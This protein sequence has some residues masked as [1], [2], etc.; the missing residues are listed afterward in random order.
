VLR[1]GDSAVITARDESRVTDLVEGYKDRAISTRL[2]VTNA[3]DVSEAVQRGVSTF[4]RIDILVNNAGYGYLGAIEESV[5]TDI[6]DMFDTNFFGLARM[7]HA[8]LPGMRQR[9]AG[10]IINISSIAGF[11]GFPS[12]GYYSASK[13]AVE[14]F[15]E[16]L[17]QEVSPLGIKVTIV[18]PGGF[19]T[20]W[21]GRSIKQSALRIA[22]YSTTAG[23]VHLHILASYGHAIGDPEKAAQQIIGAAELEEPPRRLVLGSDALKSARERVLHLSQEIDSCAATAGNTDFDKP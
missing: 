23:A 13:F 19:R 5:E 8:V 20:D 16:V 2:D 4:G 15:S 9:R 18:E 17:A 22:D 3:A 7:V 14:G 11:V 1:R 10:H 12:V 21:G 6:R